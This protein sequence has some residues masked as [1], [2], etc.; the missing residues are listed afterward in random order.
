MQNKN[1]SAKQKPYLVPIIIMLIL[2][3]VLFVPAGSI[4]YWEAWIF[5]IGFSSITFFIAAYFTKKAPELLSRRMKNKEKETSKKAPLLFKLYYIGF[6]L[7][8]LDFRFHWSNVPAWIVIISNIIAFSGYIFIIFVFKENS[9]AS[10]VIQI[11]NEQHVITT[12]P[13]SIVRHPMYLGLIII[14]MFMPLALGS[15]WSV[16]PMLL[17]IPLTVYRIKG[18]EEV[19]S[20]GL[21]GYKEYCSKTRYRLIPFIW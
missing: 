3:V 16:I 21:K 10:T 6:I 19:L 20:K 18:E 14:S 4:N 11:E 9:F 2:G 5:W 8:G 12:G 13:Y 7:P 17:I 15:F 1:N